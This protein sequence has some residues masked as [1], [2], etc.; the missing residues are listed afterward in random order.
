MKAKTLWLVALLAIGC[1]TLAGCNKSEN[2]EIANPA[3]VYCE[4]NWG[5]LKLEDGSWLC[6]FNDWS[7]CEE[8]S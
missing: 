7:Y 4:E 8:W 1:L 5:T 2:T 3:S 6:M